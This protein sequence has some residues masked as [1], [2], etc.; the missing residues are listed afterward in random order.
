MIA[1]MTEGRPLEAPIHGEGAPKT[2]LMNVIWIH[3]AMDRR[4]IER[5]P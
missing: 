3:G 2:L 5:A 4:T 1:G